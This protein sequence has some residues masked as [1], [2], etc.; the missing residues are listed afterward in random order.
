MEKWLLNSIK[1]RGEKMTIQT[2]Y[3]TAPNLFLKGKKNNLLIEKWGK[4]KEFL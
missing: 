2:D 3:L 4:R 1:G